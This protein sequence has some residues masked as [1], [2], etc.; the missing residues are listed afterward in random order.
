M[1]YTVIG[2][3]NNDHQPPTLTVAAVVEGRPTIVDEEVGPEFAQRWAD[4]VEADTPQGAEDEA[5][6]LVAG[7]ED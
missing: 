7:M 6:L 2:L 3:I 1:I 4:M 5:H